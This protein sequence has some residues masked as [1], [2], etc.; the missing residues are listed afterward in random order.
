MV[1]DVHAVLLHGAGDDL[2]RWGQAPGVEGGVSVYQPDS[3]RM[4]IYDVCMKYKVTNTPLMVFA[5]HE[6]GKMRY[7]IYNGGGPKY[8]KTL[9]RVADKDYEGV[10]F[11]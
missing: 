9:R 11:S 3:E 10:S 6:Y 5:G 8:A 7:N 2:G 4:S 1:D